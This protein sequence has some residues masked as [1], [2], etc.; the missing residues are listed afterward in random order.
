MQ[1]SYHVIIQHLFRSLDKEFVIFNNRNI[2]LGQTFKLGRY[3]CCLQVYLIIFPDHDILIGPYIC[4]V[5]IENLRL[6]RKIT[7]GI[8]TPVACVLLFRMNNTIHTTSSRY[9]C[10]SRGNASAI[11]RETHCQSWPMYYSLV[12]SSQ[13]L[14]L[15]CLFQTTHI[16]KC[17]I[18]NFG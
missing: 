12:N 7:S 13:S 2:S 4:Y 5:H 1:F 10:D 18:V 17:L 8:C 15:N 6:F 16:M 9:H 11:A 14:T 3:K